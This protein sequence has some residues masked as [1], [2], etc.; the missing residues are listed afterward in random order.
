MKDLEQ[1]SLPEAI[2]YGDST[3]H[4]TLRVWLEERGRY[5]KS[6]IEKPAKTQ[7]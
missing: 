6:S 3:V 4:E 2:K 7:R 1:S 5:Y